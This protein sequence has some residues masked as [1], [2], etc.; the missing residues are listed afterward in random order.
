[1]G[2]FV[3]RITLASNF[4]DTSSLNFKLKSGFIF[5]GF[6]FKGGQDRLVGNLCEAISV[7]RPDI[8][9]EYHE[10]ISI[11]CFKRLILFSGMESNEC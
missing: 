9:S 8:A 6:C 10:N 1:M 5:L 4:F 11:Y 7:L 2:Y 3:T